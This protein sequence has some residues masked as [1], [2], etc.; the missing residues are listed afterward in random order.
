MFRAASHEDGKG[1][2]SHKGK[3]PGLRSCRYEH[4]NTSFIEGWPRWGSMLSGILAIPVIILSFL[5]KIRMKKT[6]VEYVE[7]IRD[8]NA[9]LAT[10]QGLVLKISNANLRV[11]AC[12]GG[13]FGQ[14][15]S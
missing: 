2:P 3:G 13:G 1:F 14:T 9:Y 7:A 12:M 15:H 4:E 5:P 8:K 11:R 6:Q 10:P